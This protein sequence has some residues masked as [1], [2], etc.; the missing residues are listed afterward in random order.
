[1]C[2][3]VTV[4]SHI[5]YVYEKVRIRYLL[6]TNIMVEEVK[7]YQLNWKQ[8]TNGIQDRTVPKLVYLYNYRGRRNMSTSECVCS[9]QS[10]R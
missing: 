6:Q 1:M 8:H 3:N 7:K 10:L 9:T 2:F 5:C 4:L